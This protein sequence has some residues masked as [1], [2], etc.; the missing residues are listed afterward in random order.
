MKTIYKLHLLRFPVMGHNHRTGKEEEI[1]VT[2]DKSQ[3]RAAGLVGQSWTF[4]QRLIPV[5]P[6]ASTG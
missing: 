6:F 5:I 1:T 3:L 2:L 4:S